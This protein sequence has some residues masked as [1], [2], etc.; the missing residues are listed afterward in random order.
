MKRYVDK[1]EVA[2]RYANSIYTINSWVRTGYIPFLRCGRLIR[3]DPEVL[4]QW[5]LERANEGRN[6]IT[7]TVTL[8]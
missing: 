8:T 5:D 3:F 4:D 2:Q 6:Q 1:K 7:P